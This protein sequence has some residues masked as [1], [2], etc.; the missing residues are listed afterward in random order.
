MAVNPKILNFPG[1]G[2][3]SSHPEKKHPWPGKCWRI[4]FIAERVGGSS[5]ISPAGALFFHRHQDTDVHLLVFYFLSHHLDRMSSINFQWEELCRVVQILKMVKWFVLI[6]CILLVLKIAAR[7]RSSRIINQH[8]KTI[9]EVPGDARVSKF[10][11]RYKRIIFLW[12]IIDGESQ[13]NK[14][15]IAS[16]CLIKARLSPERSRSSSVMAG[17]ESWW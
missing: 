11:F 15:R 8:G 13:A 4:R 3:A 2:F 12:E 6:L 16:S 10:A 17:Q 14:S 1:F 5:R 7:R 9:P